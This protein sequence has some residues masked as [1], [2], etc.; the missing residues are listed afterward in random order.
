MNNLILGIPTWIITSIILAII[1]APFIAKI[2]ENCTTEIKIIFM[3]LTPMSFFLLP[4]VVLFIGIV[5]LIW[6]TPKYINNYIKNIKKEI[7]IDEPI[8]IFANFDS[9]S[10]IRYY[11]IEQGDQK[12]KIESKSIELIM[13]IKECL[14]R[15]EI[16]WSD[17]KFDS[18]HYKSTVENTVKKIKESRIV[19]KIKIE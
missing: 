8:E 1:E 4:F 12:V 7:A 2:D 13:D 14:E 19:N 6:K 3:I 9:N 15:K 17:V 10:T 11:S 18:E 16:S 5:S